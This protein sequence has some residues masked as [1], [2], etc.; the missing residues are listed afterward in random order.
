MIRAARQEGAAPDVEAPGQLAYN[1]GPKQPAHTM[2]T[3]SGPN[4]ANM[5]THLTAPGSAAAAAYPP[6]ADR[7]MMGGRYAD[8]KALPGEDQGK[9]PSAVTPATSTVTGLVWQDG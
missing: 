8:S 2:K 3:V 9:V 6:Y 5:P 7:Q 1:Q 4:T